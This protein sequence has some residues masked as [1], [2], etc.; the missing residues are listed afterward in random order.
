MGRRKKDKP[1][2]YNPPPSGPR[3]N[4]IRS[5]FDCRHMKVNLGNSIRGASTPLIGVDPTLQSQIMY[6]LMVARCVRG[7]LIKGDG[8][9][10]HFQI[11][12]FLDQGR[13][14]RYAYMDWEQANVC[15]DEFESMD[16]G[17]A[18]SSSITTPFDR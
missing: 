18:A 14:D 6:S 5:C 17:E 10:K 1:Y 16:D 15:D 9:E 4:G 12:R 11:G 2:T 13:L 3:W 7:R 8:K